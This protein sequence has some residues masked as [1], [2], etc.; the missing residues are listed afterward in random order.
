[1]SQAEGVISMLSRTAIFV[2]GFVPLSF[3]SSVEQEYQKQLYFFY[4]Q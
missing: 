4:T 3:L 1:M 2:M